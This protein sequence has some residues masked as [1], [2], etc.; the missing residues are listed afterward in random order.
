MLPERAAFP[1]PSPVRQ[2]RST[3]RCRGRCTDL[4]GNKTFTPAQVRTA[5]YTSAVDLGSPVKDTVFGYVR[6]DALTM[7]NITPSTGYQCYGEPRLASTMAVTGISITMVTG[8][9]YLQ[10]VTD[11]FPTEQPAGHNSSG[12]GME[13]GRARSG[14]SRTA[15]G[16]SIT[17]VVA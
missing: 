14:F 15:S 17:V 6:A 16:T 2:C 1:K 10:L 12:T 9:S 5:L 7:A 11:I 3:S 13:T 4:G 8:S